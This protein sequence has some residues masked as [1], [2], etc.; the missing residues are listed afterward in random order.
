MI[1]IASMQLLEALARHVTDMPRKVAVREVGGPQILTYQELA[2]RVNQLAARLSNHLAPGSVV[3]L[4]APNTSAFHIAF[5][6]ALA[7]GCSVFPFS[8][9]AVEPELISAATQSRAAAVIATDDVLRTLADHVGVALSIDD[10]AREPLLHT[11]QSQHAEPHPTLLLQTSGTTGHPG[12]VRRSTPSIDAVS[13]NVIE[14]IGWHHA[15]H[16]L[17]TIPLC[18]SYG[19]EH[20]LL[21]PVLSG[22][23][24]HLCRSFSL[25]TVLHELQHTTITLFPGV[26]SI[27]EMLG[28]L[29]DQDARFASVRTAY[30]AGAI[31]PPR[32]SE[33]MRARFGMRIGQVYGAT[34]VGSVT[35]NDPHAASFDPASAGLPMRDVTIRVVTSSGVP[36]LQ[37][38]EGHVHISAP[39]LFTGYVGGDGMEINGGFFWAGDIARVSTTGHLT[40]TGR[41]KLL[42]DVGGLK[43]NPI[44]VEQLLL[45]HPS[46]GECVVVPIALSDTVNRLK[47][48]IIPRQESAPPAADELTRFARARLTAYKIP[49]LFEIRDFLPKTATGKVLRHLIEA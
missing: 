14:A 21:A 16:V 20:G 47:A 42:I 6:A 2:A 17:A 41:H 30:S 33:S 44:E 39:S 11:Q 19:L 28:R 48:V 29:A 25:A 37:G 10:L 32:V 45:E 49:R 1:D 34:E 26:P 12:I 36:S 3:L 27:F 13:R 18:H 8:P 4:C 5:L 15:D 38:T 24:V 40:I 46:V 35:F 31:L 9:D 23:T 7:A 43:V 22:A